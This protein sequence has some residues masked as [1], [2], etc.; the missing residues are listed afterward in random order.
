MGGICSDLVTA[1]QE[2]WVEYF[3]LC[4]CE[5]AEVVVGV[6][7]DV[8]AVRRGLMWVGCCQFSWLREVYPMVGRDFSD[9]VAMRARERWVEYV[10]K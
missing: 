2:W 8:V 1:R 4:G 9:L 3:R 7:S 10:R 5:G 6:F